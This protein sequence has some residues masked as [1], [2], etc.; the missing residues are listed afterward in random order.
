M[1]T[2]LGIPRRTHHDDEESPLRGTLPFPK[3][4]RKALAD[5]QLRRNLAHATS[6]IR[7]KRAQVVDEMPDWEALREAGSAVKTQVMA[8][9]PELLE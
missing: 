9:M 6:V 8:R 7:A 4:A 3:A 5:D 2:F 1:T